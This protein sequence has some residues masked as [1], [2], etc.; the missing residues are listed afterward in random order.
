MNIRKILLVYFFKVFLEAAVHNQCM[1]QYTVK[2]SHV[3]APNTLTEADSR[4]SQY[5]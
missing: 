5:C 4:F 1:H 3:A 2:S